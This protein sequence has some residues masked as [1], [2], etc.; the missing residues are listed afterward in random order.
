ML[1]EWGSALAQ[2]GQYSQAESRFREVLAQA[3]GS[4]PAHLN[5]AL[6]LEAQDKSAEALNHYRRAME[7]EPNPLA[8]QRLRALSGA[9]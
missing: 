1:F 2:S 5:L 9:S 3:P 4:A 6:T 7:I 8:A